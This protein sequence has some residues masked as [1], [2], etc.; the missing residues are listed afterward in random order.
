MLGGGGGGVENLGSHQA[1]IDSSLFPLREGNYTKW[2]GLLTMDKRQRKGKLVLIMG[3]MFSGKTSRLIEFLEREMIAGRKISLFKPKIDFRYAE[4]EVVTHKGVRLPAVVVATT[5]E[6]VR[7]IIISGSKTDAVGLDEGQFWPLD[8]GLP[9]ALEELCF[10]GKTVYVSV[11]NRDHRGEPFGSAMELLARADDVY[12]L[13]AVCAKCGGDAYFTQR[14]LSG[15]EVF[16][17]Q[18]QVGGK[19]LYEPRCRSC[20]VRPPS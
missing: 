5:K 19:E 6:G 7:R 13:T 12:S 17:E 14:V 3:P 20:F 2:T 16:G 4:S 18:V 1:V 9:R 15:K 10:D 8:T 11:L